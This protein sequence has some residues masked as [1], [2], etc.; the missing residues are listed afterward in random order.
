LA[1]RKD[2]YIGC[3]FIGK[4]AEIKGKPRKFREILEKQAENGTNNGFSVDKRWTK[5]HRK[6]RWVRFYPH[7]HWVS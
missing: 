4:W 5:P 2:G 1:Y 6:R 7:K 3:W